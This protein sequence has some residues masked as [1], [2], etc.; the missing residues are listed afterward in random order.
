VLTLRARASS[1]ND[2]GLEQLLEAVI[3]LLVREEP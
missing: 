3:S 2:D 1:W